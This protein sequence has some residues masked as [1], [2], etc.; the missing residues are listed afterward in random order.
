MPWVRWRLRGNEVGPR[1][2]RGSEVVSAWQCGGPLA[3]AW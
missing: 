1:C 2:L 3:L